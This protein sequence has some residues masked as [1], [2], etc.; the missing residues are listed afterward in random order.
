MRR[1]G[2]SG[3][4]INALRAVARWFETRSSEGSGINALQPVLVQPV[5]EDGDRVEDLVAPPEEL[6]AVEAGGEV[7]VFELV[8][9]VP[10]VLRLDAVVPG[11]E[12]DPQ[13]RVAPLLD[14]HQA[15]LQLLPEAGRGPVLDGEARPFGD[16]RILV[17]VEPD[18]FVAEVERRGPPVPPLAD[19]GEAQAEPL[20]HREQP[21]E[22]RG[23]EPEGAAIDRPL[24]ADQ[25][26]VA[27]AVL[28]LIAQRGGARGL[29]LGPR[30][31]VD[32]PSSFIRISLA[33]C[34]CWSVGALVTRKSVATRN[35][36]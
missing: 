18:Q 17:A 10:G 14:L 4:A 35:W 12:G 26:G 13:V 1:K 30:P 27:L 7:D 36:F 33:E 32:H 21:L 9:R 29:P 20:G 8:H 16:L 31:A 23:A 34:A 19:L 2:K 3:A 6:V 5:P 25:L 28:R 11:E 24:G 15:V 22:M